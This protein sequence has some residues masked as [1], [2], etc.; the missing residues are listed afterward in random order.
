MSPHYFKA[1]LLGG[2][3]VVP[4]F[5]IQFDEVILLTR[6]CDLSRFYPIPGLCGKDASCSR[7][8]TATGTLQHFMLFTCMHVPGFEPDGNFDFKNK[9]QPEVCAL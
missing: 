2:T 1:L 9:M 8:L 3:W 7:P 4:S 5:V 6:F